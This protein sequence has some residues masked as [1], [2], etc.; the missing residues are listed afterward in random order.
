MD[1]EFEVL[2]PD[3]RIWAEGVCAF[4]VRYTPGDARDRGAAYADVIARMDE[5]T[6][7]EER[8]GQ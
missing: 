4:V 6:I 8:S 3:G 5:G 1:A 2:A 7:L